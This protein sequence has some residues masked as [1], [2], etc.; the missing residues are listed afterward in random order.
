[1]YGGDE[2]KLV[3]AATTF[4]KAVAKLAD[5]AESIARSLRELTDLVR[6][7]EEGR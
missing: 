6:R 5:Q 4:A 3:E 1:M 2:T 7:S